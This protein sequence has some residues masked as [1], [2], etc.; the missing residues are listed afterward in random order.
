MR[1]PT[2]PSSW[3]AAPSRCAAAGRSGSAVRNGR[4]WSTPTGSTATTGTPPTDAE[5]RPDPARGDAARRLHRLEA[6]QRL[7]RHALPAV[8]RRRLLAALARLG[9][10]TGRVR[11]LARQS[12]SGAKPEDGRCSRPCPARCPSVALARSGARGAR[13]HDRPRVGQD[14]DQTADR[15]AGRRARARQPRPQGDPPSLHCVFLG[16]PG[17]GKTTVARLMG[18]IL[19]GLGYLR[20]GHLIEADRSTLVAGYLGQT[21]LK[22]REAVENA[23]DGVLFIDEAYSL[24]G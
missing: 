21:A 7:R 3:P 8:R 9:D 18:E 19:H 4:A 20:R 15:C 1:V 2:R 5:R 14:G 11:F 17:T 10:L 22:T 23:L 6:A 16:N 13:R 24:A 12:R